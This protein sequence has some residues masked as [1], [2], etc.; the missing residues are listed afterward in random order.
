MTI[1]TKKTG[2]TDNTKKMIDEFSEGFNKGL[3][4]EREE[5]DKM[6]AIHDHTKGECLTEVDPAEA[7]KFL[8]D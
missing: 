7:D 5:H 6:P 2:L 3:K 8:K 1:P 4:R